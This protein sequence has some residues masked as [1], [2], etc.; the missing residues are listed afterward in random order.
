MSAEA[1][2]N[3]PAGARKPLTMDE[4]RAAVL[5]KAEV[6]GE[7]GVGGFFTPR[8]APEKKALLEQALE[9]LE[10]EKALIADRRKSKPRYFHPAFAPQFPTPASVA[11]K[12]R[13]FAS[14]LYPALLKPPELKRPLPPGDRRLFREAL[15]LLI[16]QRSLLELRR[17]S[18][19]FF[20]ESEGVRQALPAAGAPGVEAPE[21]FRKEKVIAAYHELERE[22]RFPD[23]A[24]SA[25]RARAEADAGELKRWIL[26]ER[27][28][29][30]AVLS[31]GDWSLADEEKR[32][33]AILAGG[34]RFLL[35]RLQP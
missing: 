12:L 34:E 24:I 8:T 29:G 25:L 15:A 11:E 21:L 16:E 9:E 26:E 10:A 2:R 28:R 27:Q 31:Y 13:H 3:W 30:R 5:R 32:S 17:G 20:V 23:V 19:S 6:A 7:R 35:V 18:S 4:A 1:Q 22:T 33:G 14:S